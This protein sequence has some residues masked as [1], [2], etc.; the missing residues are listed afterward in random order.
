MKDFKEIEV[1]A[2]VD[3]VEQVAYIIDGSDLGA[4]LVSAALDYGIGFSVPFDRF[5]Q[6]G[7]ENKVWTKKDDKLLLSEQADWDD[8]YEYVSKL[9]VF[10]LASLN[11]DFLKI[12]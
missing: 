2:N 11:F 1:I 7:I 5:V 9:E 3:G 4:N 6:A 8:F 12:K 10:N